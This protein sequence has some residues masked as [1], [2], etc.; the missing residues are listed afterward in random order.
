MSSGELHSACVFT[1][2]TQTFSASDLGAQQSAGREGRTVRS[3]GSQIVG[4]PSFPQFDT[5]A[6]FGFRFGSRVMSPTAGTKA[7]GMVIFLA[8]SS[9]L[10]IFLYRNFR[11][12]PSIPP[13][14]LRLP[15]HAS[16]LRAC[17]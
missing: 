14:E 12:V 10:F 13:A 15:S 3:R 4:L 17:H 11:T 8:R 6:G 1:C 7:L 9:E 5:I 2:K 16:Q